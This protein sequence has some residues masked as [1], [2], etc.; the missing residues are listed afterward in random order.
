VIPNPETCWFT[1]NRT[2]KK[3]INIPI[4][5]PASTALSS[6]IHK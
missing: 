3:P 6:P 5:I 4:A 1:P 2:V